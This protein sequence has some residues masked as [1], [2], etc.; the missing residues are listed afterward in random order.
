[1]KQFSPEHTTAYTEL[2]MCSPTCL[3]AS[4]KPWFTSEKINNMTFSLFT[5]IFQT[6]FILQDQMVELLVRNWKLCG[7][8]SSRHALF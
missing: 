8:K 5:D 6:V 1:M 3:A 4:G 7:E 2:K